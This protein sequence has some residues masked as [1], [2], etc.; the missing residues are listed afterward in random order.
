MAA[1]AQVTASLSLSIHDASAVGSSRTHLPISRLPTFT[2]ARNGT[3]FATGSPFLISRTSYQKK[4]AG[5]ATFVSVRC[6]QNTQD[7]SSVD[8]WIGRLAMVAFAGAIGVEIATGKG[9]L[10][11]F[12][13]TNPLPTVALAVTGLM[14]VLAAVFIFQSASKN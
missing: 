1:V 6:E 13:L 3:T 7:G 8:V 10:E 14:G 5:R 11:N 9:L 2:F 4:A 12:G